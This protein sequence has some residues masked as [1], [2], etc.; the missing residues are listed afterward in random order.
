[1]HVRRAVLRGAPPAASSLSPGAINSS[2]A[3][4]N[5]S[6]HEPEEEVA[7]DPPEIDAARLRP[8]CR[9]GGIRFARLG[10]EFEILRPRWRD[11]EPLAE[12]LGARVPSEA[13]NNK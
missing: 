10:T 7:L 12:E 9:L 3:P 11:V 4:S 2:S 6:E 1:M 8:I 13:T 5:A